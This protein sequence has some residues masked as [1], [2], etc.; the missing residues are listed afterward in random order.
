MSSAFTCWQNFICKW[1]CSDISSYLVVSYE[2]TEAS[3]C[4]GGLQEEIFRFRTI[5]K[6]KKN[7]EKNEQEGSSKH[8][9]KP[10]HLRTLQASVRCPA[11]S[12]SWEFLLLV[13]CHHH[14]CQSLRWQFPLFCASQPSFQLLLGCTIFHYTPKK[15]AEAGISACWCTLEEGAGPSACRGERPS[16]REP[17]P[18]LE[19]PQG[20]AG[21][22]I[23]GY[24]KHGVD[25][26]GMVAASPV[27]P[28]AF[29]RAPKTVQGRRTPLTLLHSGVKPAWIPLLVFVHIRSPP[30][31]PKY[32]PQQVVAGTKNITEC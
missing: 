1:H 12:I 15:E 24:V 4:T 25:G 28:L 22:A 16:F 2:E 9:A 14:C 21:Q 5:C 18:R 26:R 13:D 31:R 29:S 19:C 11:I 6:I 8:Q 17:C 3:I 32:D 27:R 7:L 30:P 20:G 10:R 23:A